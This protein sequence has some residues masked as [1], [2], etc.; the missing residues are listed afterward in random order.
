MKTGGILP[1]TA[2]SKP[3]KID[4]W[5][6]G[7]ARIEAHR[8][9]DT[10]PGSSDRPDPRS[11]AATLEVRTGVDVAPLAR[12][13]PDSLHQAISDEPETGVREE[14]PDQLDET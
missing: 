6:R 1:P 2:A 7:S 8:G 13:G 5:C 4:E 14:G 11:V 9:V 3:T 10:A 12:S